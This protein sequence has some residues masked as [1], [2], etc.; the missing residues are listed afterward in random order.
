MS[1]NIFPAFRYQNAPAAMLWLEKAF[2]FQKEVEIPAPDGRIAHAQL[3][4]GQGAV[5]LGSAHEEPG[6][7]N[8]WSQEKFGV[9]VYVEQID[10]HC[11]R[12]KAAGAE[13]VRDLQD[14]PYGSREYSVR[15][16]EGFLWSFGT[17]RPKT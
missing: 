1:A 2:G 5:L 3:N 6:K 8:P 9:Y 13:I 10:Q 17:Y 7:E 4:L 15:D 12:T 16:L 14:T 11:A